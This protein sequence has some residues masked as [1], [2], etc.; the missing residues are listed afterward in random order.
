ML[1]EVDVTKLD[2]LLA[3]IDSILD[4]QPR[5]VPQ[6]CKGRSVLASNCGRWSPELLYN[7][8]VADL[9]D[10]AN[11]LG[12]T[13]SIRLVPSRSTKCWPLQLRWIQQF[14]KSDFAYSLGHTRYSKTTMA[15]YLYRSPT[16][17]IHIL[18][19]VGESPEMFRNMGQGWMH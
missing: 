4:A 10:I 2:E 9:H 17:S 11:A 13:P 8:L 6:A 12:V 1:Q 18:F 16:L 3:Q 15:H 7:T 14:N 19:C 5:Q